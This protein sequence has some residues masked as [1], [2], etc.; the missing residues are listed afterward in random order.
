MNEQ[1]WLART[2]LLLGEEKL[3]QLGRKHILVVGL[4]GVGAYAAEQLARAGVGRLT[5][6]DADKV[7]PT[8]INRQLIASTS[9][10]GRFKTDL[11]AA[12]LLDINPGIRLETIYEYLEDKHFNS[13]LD[14]C[15]FDYVVDAIDTLTPKVYLLYHCIKKSIPVVSSMGA[16]GRTDPSLIGVSDIGHTIHCQFAQAVRK[17]LHKLGV[18]HGAKAVFSTEKVPDSAIIIDFAERNRKTVTGTISY[19]PALFGCWCASVVIRDL[20][21][22]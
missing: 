16:G 22:L 20:A 4:G 14:S 9:A 10:L 11:V 2:R 3:S 1:D 18:H 15:H 19:M 5:I 12:R 13:L 7:N 6:A 8:N 21:G 17:R